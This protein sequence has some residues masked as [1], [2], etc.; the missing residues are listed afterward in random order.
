MLRDKTA[1]VGIGQTEY[2]RNSGRSEQSLAVEAILNAIRDAGLQPADIDGIIKFN[3]DNSAVDVQLAANLGI[4]NLRFFSEVGHLGGAGCGTVAHAAA[5]II[6]GLATNV[7]CFRAMN[8]RSGARFGRGYATANRPIDYPDL[9]EP[10]GIISPVHRWGFSATRHMHEFGT[11]NEH[12]GWISVTAR[13]HA[14]HN[15]NAIQ[16]KPITIEDHQASRWI[17]YPHRILDCCLE[18]DGACAVVVAPAERARD[19]RQPPVYVMGA[20]QGSGMGGDEWLGRSWPYFN[21]TDLTWTEAR[22]AAEEVYRQAGVGPAAIDVAQIYD[23]FSSCV[24]LQLEEFGFCGKGEGGPFVEGGQRIT[25][26]GDIPINTSGGMLA[27]A[28]VH[29]MN[30]VVEGVRQLRGTSS[31]QIPDAEIGLVTSGVPG[32]PT[33]ALILRR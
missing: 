18:T 27:E 12:F 13:S 14:V 30:L 5:A 31:F 16:R 21:Y 19:L 26:G 20:G 10:F 7:V 32:T 33:S 23:N 22:H 4:P 24:L 8:G 25:R 9:T 17:T 29:G 28:Y 2:S 3:S 6:A 15:P 11:T 1:I